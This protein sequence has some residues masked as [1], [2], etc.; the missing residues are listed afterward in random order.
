MKYRNTSRGFTLIELLVAV[1]IIGILA[2][3]AVPQYKKAVVKSKFAELKLLHEDIHKAR[4]LYHD[5]TGIWPNR[6]DVLDIQFP[7]KDD[8]TCELGTGTCWSR[9]VSG[10]NGFHCQVAS[11]DRIDC[12]RTLSG[13]S[14]SV[15]Y[16][17]GQHLCCF[18]Y[19]GEEIK[20]LCA[21]DTG[22]T[23]VWTTVPTC[24]L[25]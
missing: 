16:Q 14:V 8:D 3:I 9:H 2:A 5:T 10:E 1:L 11:T 15:S 13:K 4:I 22:G 17:K 23:K 18:T 24:Y 7:F 12:M 21:L 19:G 20:A 25:Y 6:L